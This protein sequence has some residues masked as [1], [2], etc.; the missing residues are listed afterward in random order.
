M[1]ITVYNLIQKLT[2]RKSEVVHL[3]RQAKKDQSPDSNTLRKE[4]QSLKLK[5]KELKA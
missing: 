2:K 1:D 3:K 5:I 4:E